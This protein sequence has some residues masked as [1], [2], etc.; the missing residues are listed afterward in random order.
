MCSS[1]REIVGLSAKLN[2]DA[3]L[4]ISERSPSVERW[5]NKD[6]CCSSKDAKAKRQTPATGP[7]SSTLRVD[8][9][10]REF[11]LN[12]FGESRDLSNV[13]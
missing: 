6:L 8:P 11:P 4:T 3:S 1:C 9:M 13:E 5:V 12:P 7:P 2:L 10:R